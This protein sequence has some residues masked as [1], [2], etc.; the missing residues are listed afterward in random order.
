MQGNRHRD[1][2]PEMAIR[3][4][5]HRLGL[6]YRVDVAPVLSLRRRRADLVFPRQRVAVFIDGCFWHGCPDH[7]RVP[8][9][10]TVYWAAKIAGNRQRDAHTSQMLAAAGWR[11]L[12]VWEHEEPADAALRIGDVVRSRAPVR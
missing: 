3:R 6:R 8:G 4:A 11:V 12:R 5:T 7:A 10:N 9:T 2:R 1:T